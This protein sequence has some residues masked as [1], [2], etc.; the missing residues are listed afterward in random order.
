ME[1]CD[2]EFKG[3]RKDQFQNPDNIPLHEGVKYVGYQE[4]RGFYK[5]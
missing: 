4:E 3:R 2:V 1:I 5:I